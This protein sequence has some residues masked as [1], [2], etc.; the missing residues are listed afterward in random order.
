MTDALQPP[1]GIKLPRKY[2]HSE[3]L[4]RWFVVGARDGKDGP[5]ALAGNRDNFESLF[6]VEAAK[7]YRNGYSAGLA[8]KP[9]IR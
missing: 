1:D 6:G 9:R 7:A 8:A 5:I 2:L 4:Q 3:E